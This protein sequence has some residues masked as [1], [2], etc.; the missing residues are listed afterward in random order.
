[1]YLI[2]SSLTHLIFILL[3][4]K[5]IEFSHKYE[6]NQD[7]GPDWVF[8]LAT[9]THALSLFARVDIGQCPDNVSMWDSQVIHVA[10]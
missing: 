7:F 5:S 4:C 2:L 6:W 10:C 1:M 9:I 8:I 3:N